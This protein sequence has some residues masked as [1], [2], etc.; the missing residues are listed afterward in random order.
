LAP[1]LVKLKIP[2][3]E[4]KKVSVIVLILTNLV[5]VFGVI[6]MD[7]D[8]FLVVFLFW[9]ENVI[10][11]FFNILKMAVAPPDATGKWGPKYKI[12]PFFCVHYGMFTLVHGFIVFAIFG[13]VFENDDLFAGISA[14]YHSLINPAFG[15]A[16]LAL[17]VSHTISFFVNYI[18][19]GE[20]KKTSLGQLMVQPYARVIILH[21]TVLIG[22]FLVMLLGSPV[23]GLILLIA[24]KT[25]VDILSHVRQHHIF[26]PA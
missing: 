20:F 11:G 6:F 15:W 1:L 4:L 14:T 9:T 7:W 3:S 8:A 21:I 24:L 13:S 26:N 23:V 2:L 5:S 22:G 18:G 17:A 25:Y 19:K 10:I 12:I 16:V